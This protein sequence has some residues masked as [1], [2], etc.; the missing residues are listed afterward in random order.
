M[1][2]KIA[3]FATEEMSWGKCEATRLEKTSKD[4]GRRGGRKGLEIVST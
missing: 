2:R 3:L 4:S 1:D